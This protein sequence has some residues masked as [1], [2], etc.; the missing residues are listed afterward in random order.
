MSGLQ[1]H[2]S[3]YRFT[4]K[5]IPSFATLILFPLLVFLG[6]W[7]LDRADEKRIIDEGIRS[8]IAKPALELNNFDLKALSTEAYRPAKVKGKFDTQ[9]Q[10]LLDN[11]THAGRPGYHVLTPFIFESDHGREAVL[12]NRGWITYQDTRENIPSIK[13][14]ENEI[15]ILGAIKE[16][17]RSIVLNETAQQQT[18]LAYTNPML[19]QSVDIPALNQHLSYTLLPILIE[20]DKT[21]ENGYIREWQPYYGSIDKHNAY[22]TQ[23]FSMAAILLFLYIKLNTKKH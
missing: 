4:P 16:I 7:Q 8:A 15:E 1:L 22:A 9:H 11:R 13:V 19:L 14:T 5:L 10:F 18:D 2:I 12:I 23:W 3:D 21:D 20:L 6:L 17:P